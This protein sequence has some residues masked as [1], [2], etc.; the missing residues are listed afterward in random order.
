MC[1]TLTDE[2]ANRYHEAVKDAVKRKLN[3]QIREG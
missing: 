3:A 2:D 1:R